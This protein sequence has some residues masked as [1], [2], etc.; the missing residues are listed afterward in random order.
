MTLQ[1]CLEEP[2]STIISPVE[3]VI[4]PCPL[5]LQTKPPYLD[6]KY[7]FLFLDCYTLN[8]EEVELNSL[9]L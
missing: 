1:P 6:L 7:F 9:K 8:D 2:E 5:T 4:V 3:P